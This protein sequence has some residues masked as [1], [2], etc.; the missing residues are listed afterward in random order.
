MEKLLLT[1]PGPHVVRHQQSQHSP[2][3]DDKP[4]EKNDRVDAFDCNCVPER[5]TIKWIGRN[6]EA[7]PSGAYIVGIHLVSTTYFSTVR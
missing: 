4:F 2:V 6:K 1:D 3:A 7:L 5:G